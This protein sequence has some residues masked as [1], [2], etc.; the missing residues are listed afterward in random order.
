MTEKATVDDDRARIVEAFT[1]L[2]AR[3][4]VLVCTGGLGPT[5]DDMTSEAVASA[6]GAKLVRD[7]E[8]L[9]HIRRRLE[10]F[11]RAVSDTNAKQADF[12][13]GAE[14]LANPVGTAPGFAVTVGECAARS[15]CPACRAR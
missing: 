12:P 9:E 11:G 15:S 2:A 13:E 5:T 6:I 1:R 7:E 14:I 10:R 4:Q 3:S 8:S